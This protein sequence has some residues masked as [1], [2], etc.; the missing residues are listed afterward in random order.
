MYRHERASLNRLTRALRKRFSE[1][2]QGIYAFG[3]KVRG[4]HGEWSDFDVLVVVN[5]RNPSIESEIMRMFV[6]EEAKRGVSFAPIIKDAG[7]F[8]KERHH[9]TPFFQ[10]VMSEG[11]R[12]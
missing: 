10:N 11:I 1:R 9:R 7:A 12:L 4:D 3:S 2:I 6:K 5:D 8:E